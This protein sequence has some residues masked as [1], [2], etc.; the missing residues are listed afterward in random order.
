MKKIYIIDAIKFVFRSFFSNAKFV[1]IYLFISVLL[2]A[3]VF[4]S[5]FIFLPKKLIYALIANDI[6]VIANFIPKFKFS[7]SYLF[8]FCIWLA[9]FVISSALRMGLSKVLLSSVDGLNQ[10][11]KDLLFGFKKIIQYVVIYALFIFQFVVVFFSARLL[12]RFFINKF[13]FEFF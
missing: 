3:A 11:K 4:S 9:Y 10:D 12:S 13:L 8:I 2:M 7:Y 6:D 5:N 1:L